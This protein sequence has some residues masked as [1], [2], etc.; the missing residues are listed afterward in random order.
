MERSKERTTTPRR[1]R[2]DS[3]LDT[4]VARW[5]DGQRPEGSPVGSGTTGS[6]GMGRA[7]QRRRS[8]TRRA[9]GPQQSRDD[10]GEAAARALPRDRSPIRAADTGGSVAAS[11][12]S[13]GAT[14]LRSGDRVRAGVRTTNPRGAAGATELAREGRVRNA[15]QVA[16][17]GHAHR[18]GS[19]AGARVGREGAANNGLRR[20]SITRPG[21]DHT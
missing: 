4:S 12:S 16:A 7:R 18:G 11:S 19:Q 15:R 21:T 9:R 5:Q 13:S 2:H 14:G 3:G 17:R 6:S 8:D 1:G 10:P 20:S